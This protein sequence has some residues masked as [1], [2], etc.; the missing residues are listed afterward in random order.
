MI[1][2]KSSLLLV[3]SLLLAPASFA[4]DTI[5]GC[6]AAAEA[7]YLNLAFFS[8]DR[9]VRATAKKSDPTDF[10]TALSCLDRIQEKNALVDL[11]NYDAELAVVAPRAKTAEIQ[12][13]ISH[14][15][16]RSILQ[17]LATGSKSPAA[18]AKLRPLVQGNAFYDA[19]TAGLIAS[20]N[21]DYSA[22]KPALRKA[23]LLSSDESATG[24]PVKAT[25]RAELKLALAR[26]LYATGEDAAAV[27]EYES[28]YKIGAPMQDALIESGWAHLRAKN[29]A[30][31]I[32]LSI[33]L[34]TGKLSQFFAPEAN[35]IR[36][37]GFV[38][39]CRFAE[40]RNAISRF[41]AEYAPVA[42]WLKSASLSNHSLYESAIARSEGVVG[43]ESVPE[44]VWSMWSTSDL[45]IA[46]QSGIRGAFAEE[47]EASEWI[48]DLG[49]ARAK[50]NA[51]ADLKKVG[52]LRA[53]AAAR[54]EAHLAKLNAG[55]ATRIAQESE[56][57]R[58]VRVE[59]SQGA[60]RDLVYRNANPGLS[61]VEK[62]VAKADRKAKSYRGKLAWGSVKAE[63]PNAE[64]WIDEI[65][66]FEAATLDRCKAKLEYKKLQAAR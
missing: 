57:M 63:D 53:R 50:A 34:S 5:M 29:Y 8:L 61:E 39:N 6:G 4:S 20:A 14:F 32:G 22:A 66:N 1:R 45:F 15:A 27:A 51:S 24:G 37:I 60:G 28:L 10:A 48:A 65:G 3:C 42:E 26:S 23:V 25:F 7:G 52:K 47:R 35:S 64:M 41:S 17:R 16:F 58:F 12:S 30:K 56:R 38:E 2:L 54:V 19:A 33:E 44:K 36:A 43:A 18:F 55:M 62:T 46:M 31:S 13:A 9:T 11:P 40:S 21:S 49:D 59:A